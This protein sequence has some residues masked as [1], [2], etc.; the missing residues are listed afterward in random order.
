MDSRSV[1]ESVLE[2]LDSYYAEKE[3][4]GHTSNEMTGV[5]EGKNLMLV[6]MESIDSWLVTE[7]YMPNLYRLQQNGWNFKNNYTPLYISA[8]TFCTES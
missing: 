3:K 6:V 2:E 5:F 7:D 4:A 8:G 1:D